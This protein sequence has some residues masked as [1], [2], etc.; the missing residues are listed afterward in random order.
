MRVKLLALALLA[1]SG[2][3][4]PDPSS[5]DASDYHVNWNERLGKCVPRPG[6]ST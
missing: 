6:R 2:L 4:Q 5:F 1:A 3:A